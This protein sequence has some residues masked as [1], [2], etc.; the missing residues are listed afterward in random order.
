MSQ[1]TPFLMTGDSLVFCC[2]NWNPI[3]LLDVYWHKL[4]WPQLPSHQVLSEEVSSSCLSFLSLSLC[5]KHVP[6]CFIV[7]HL[8]SP[9]YILVKPVALCF[10]LFHCI[11]CFIWFIWF[12]VC[13]CD[14]GSIWNDRWESKRVAAALPSGLHF[15]IISHI[16][17][18]KVSKW[19]DTGWFFLLVPP[20]KSSKY[21][22][23]NLG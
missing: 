16:S 8:V 20:L 4:S 15:N 6:S 5:L 19:T 17:A 7:L 18:M 10:I 14:Q 21:K 2:R 9:C 11:Y 23:V 22:K 3:F 1:M 13:V 12:I